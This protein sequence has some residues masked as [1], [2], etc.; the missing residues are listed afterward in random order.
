MKKQHIKILGSTLIV[1]AFLLL[2]FG[3]EDT[4]SKSSSGG[5]SSSS[6]SSSGEFSCSWCDKSFSGEFYASYTRLVPCESSTSL[7]SR[8]KDGDLSM[9]SKKCSMRCCEESFRNNG[10]RK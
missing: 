2:A 5:S 3:S 10:R 6:S 9:F 4:K 8:S 1:G 7:K